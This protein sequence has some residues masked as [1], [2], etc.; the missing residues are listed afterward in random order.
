MLHFLLLGSALFGVYHWR[1]PFDSAQGRGATPDGTRVVRITVQ[2]VQWLQETWARQ[3]QR[4]PDERELRGLVADYVKELLL[5]REAQELGLAENDTIVR[6]R[7]AQKMEFLMEDT[8]R[9]PEPAEAELR[10]WYEARR[11]PYE[12]P[13]RITF[14]QLFFN[15][16]VD[17]RQA[18]GRE[19]EGDRIMLER[20]YTG[21]DEQAIARDFGAEFAIAVMALEP[22]AWRGPI[23]SGYGFHLVR[24]QARTP[25]EPLPFE[26]ARAQALVDWQREHQAKA[27]EQ[28][29]A[30]LIN[31][32]DVVAD[33][34]I[35]PLVEAVVRGGVENR[36]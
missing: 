10:A 33:E 22:G 1:Q 20:E 15:S 23:Q 19:V 14:T 17:A 26:D 4:P 27:H 18:L 13:A 9:L 36:E 34:R 35:K 2:E 8:A 24:V 29:M 3:W 16:E 5:A 21:A 12:I 7:L 6:R 28:F 32:Y 30:A 25:A 11:P 31:K